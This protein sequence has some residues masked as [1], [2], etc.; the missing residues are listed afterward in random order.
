MTF[1][2]PTMS[3]RQFNNNE[4]CS[5]KPVSITFQYKGSAQSLLFMGSQHSTI[6]NKTYVTITI[7]L[8]ITFSY[9]VLLHFFTFYQKWFM[10][11][12]RPETLVSL[13]DDGELFLEQD[14]FKINLQRHPVLLAVLLWWCELTIDMTWRD[15]S[16]LYVMILR[17]RTKSSFHC[18]V[19]FM[20]IIILP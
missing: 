19:I 17:D 16:I 11:W 20:I 4:F 10:D 9:F 12:N 7:E 14:F 5:W 15:C 8:W 18:R 2:I 6:N 1:P 3:K 13:H